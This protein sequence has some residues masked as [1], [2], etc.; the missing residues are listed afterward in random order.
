MKT[1]ILVLFTVALVAPG[2]AAVSHEKPI[3]FTEAV[4]TFNQDAKLDPIGKD[5][6]VLTE[7]AVVAAIRWAMIEREKLQVTDKTFR[8][9]GEITKSR[10]LP[11]DF[12]LEVLTGYEP[13][14]EVAFDVWSVRLRIPGGSFPGGS[15][16]INIQEKMI[17]S[18]LIGE[19]ER[20]MIQKWRKKEEERGGI[21]SFERVEWMRK[22]RAER[23]AA[24]AADNRNPTSR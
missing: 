10:I 3:S 6:P 4:R 21:G 8:Q 12:E 11:K 20:K 22:Y 17:L 16:C 5:Q 18:R 7:D 2:L 14:D 13:N 9:L 24:A 1:I 19:R 15:T 23:E